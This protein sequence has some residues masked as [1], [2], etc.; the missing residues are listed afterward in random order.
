MLPVDDP[1]FIGF[2]SSFPPLCGPKLMSETPRLSNAWYQTIHDDGEK[3]MIILLIHAWPPWCLWLPQP[4]RMR[5][6]STDLF[7]Y[8]PLLGRT[9]NLLVTGT[10]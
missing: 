4:C 7:G 2:C 5:R 10:I 8:V 9:G 3:S 6:A 1:V